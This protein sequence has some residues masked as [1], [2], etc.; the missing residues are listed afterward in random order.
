[1]LLPKFAE[2]TWKVLDRSPPKLMREVPVADCDVVVVGGG[3]AGLV[4]ARELS[5][6]GHEVIVVEGRD[7]LGGRTW[8][9]QL[10][11]TPTVP[12]CGSG[13]AARCGR[14]QR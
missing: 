12:P 1:M 8:S 13:A 14:Q 4:A 7:R 10:N 6:A 3:F 2:E 9:K 5:R 11:R